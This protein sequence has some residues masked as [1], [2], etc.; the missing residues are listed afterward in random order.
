[1]NKKFAVEPDD[2]KKY[3]QKARLSTSVT[4][5]RRAIDMVERRS[6]VDREA[7]IEE[8]AKVVE[9]IDFPAPRK[10]HRY[11]HDVKYSIVAAIRSLADKGEAKS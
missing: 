8:C 5:L 11:Q 4:E 2:F 3:L 6:A 7:V 1:M 10:N 9:S